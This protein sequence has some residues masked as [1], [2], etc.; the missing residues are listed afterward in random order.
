MLILQFF[1]VVP[2]GQ[3]FA[4]TIENIPNPEGNV[5][6]P[7]PKGRKEANSIIRAMS[8]YA[9]GG[10]RIKFELKEK[11]GDSY[12]F[13]AGGILTDAFTETAVPTNMDEFRYPD[14]DE[15]RALKRGPVRR[16]GQAMAA[17]IRTFLLI[18]K[19]K[20]G[21]VLLIN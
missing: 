5:W 9:G 13:L 17:A 1:K 18:T 7:F 20:T 8:Q 14:T 10:A 15:F 11:R 4:G 16:C 2:E 6:N 19:T 21:V 3:P 12:S